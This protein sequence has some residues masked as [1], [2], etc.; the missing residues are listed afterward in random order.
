MFEPLKI[1]TL[2][3]AILHDINAFL[4]TLGSVVFPATHVIP[5]NTLSY[6]FKICAASSIQSASSPPTSQS[7]IK[8]LDAGILNYLRNFFLLISI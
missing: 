5:N 4:T 1:G 8:Y 2:I 7:I 3:P 6:F